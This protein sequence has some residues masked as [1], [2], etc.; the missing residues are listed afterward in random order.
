MLYTFLDSHI[1]IIF[2]III[3]DL[4]STTKLIFTEYG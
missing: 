1:Y 4:T 3:R 2:F